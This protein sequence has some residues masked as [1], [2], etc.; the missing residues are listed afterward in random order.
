MAYD[1]FCLF[2]IFWARTLI[3][4]SIDYYSVSLMAPLP[5]TAV[6]TNLL[7]EVVTKSN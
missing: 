2:S 6:V 3:S 7:L 4:E 1:L 5:L